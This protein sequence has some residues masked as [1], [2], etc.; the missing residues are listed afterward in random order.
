MRGAPNSPSRSGSQP[1]SASRPPPGGGQAGEVGH[2]GAG[3]KSDV[4][5]VREAKEVHEPATGRVLD[6]RHGGRGDARHGVLVP[7]AD[8]PV[9]GQCGRQRPANHPAEKPPGGHGHQSGFGFVRQILHH[10]CGGHAPP[11][12]AGP[13]KSAARSWALWAGPTCRPAGSPA[14]RRRDGPRLTMLPNRVRRL[15]TY[16]HGTP[17]RHGTARLAP[18]PG[19]AKFSC[20]TSKPSLM[21][22]APTTSRNTTR[23][24]LLPCLTA[25]RGPQVAARHVG[26]AQQQADTPEE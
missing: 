7:R 24:N 25:V 18:T 22:R 13:P 26:E 17:G 15:R 4:G 19:Q 11:P 6:G 21:I 12:G 16:L 23:M 1:A 9:G 20:Q 8:Q 3:D 5:S 10:V 2:R 14:I